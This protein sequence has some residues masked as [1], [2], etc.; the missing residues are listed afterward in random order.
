M[1]EK[2]YDFLEIKNQMEKLVSTL[3]NEFGWFNE[4]EL[5]ETPRRVAQFYLD[6]Y[7][8][9]SKEFNFT[10]FPVKGK[11]SLITIKNLEF[12]SVCGHHILPFTG[13]IS[14]AYLPWDEQQHGVYGGISKFART[15]EKFSRKPQTQE[16]MT[17]EIT[18]FL[19]SNLGDKN[20]TI[21][22]YRHPR[23]LFV[24]VSEATHTCTTIRGAEQHHPVMGTNGMRWADTMTQ[25]EVESLRQEAMMELK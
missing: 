14:I 9:S 6:W 25:Q 20:S 21:E 10:T 8:K 16:L 19:W 3:H 11:A 22:R 1:E 12:A 18:D 2:K 23:F 4:E 24:Q 7:S 5:R 15:V 13:K 17:E